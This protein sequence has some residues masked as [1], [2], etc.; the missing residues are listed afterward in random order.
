MTSVDPVALQREYYARTAL[1]YEDSHDAYEHDLAIGHIIGFTRWLGAR[2]LLDTGCGTGRAMRLIG[3]AIPTLE[4][5]GNDPSRELLEVAVSRFG[6]PA[7]QLDCVPTDRLPYP[8]ESFDVVVATGIMHHVPNP[9]KILQGMLRVARQA[10]F[11]S[12]GNM[13]GHGPLVS[14]LAKLLLSRTRLLDPV[15]RL[16]RGGHTWAYFD[17]DGVTWNYSIY[18]SMSFVRSWCAE[19]LVIPTLRHDDVN[20]AL[21][22]LLWSSHGLLCGFKQRLPRP[23]PDPGVATAYAGRQTDANRHVS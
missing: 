12:D 5:R 2:S 13:Y 4:V 15:N 22:P 10:I 21:K 17:G 8:D 16:R 11:V 19:V 23:S 18:D 1:E 3:A 9:T 20:G 6:V 7:D 14:R